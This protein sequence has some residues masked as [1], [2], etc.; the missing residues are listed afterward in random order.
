M[1]KV[2]V[3]QAET[4]KSTVVAPEIF[5]A[6]ARRL[7]TLIVD[8]QLDAKL[9]TQL[10]CEQPE[11]LSPRVYMFVAIVTFLALAVAVGCGLAGRL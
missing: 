7:R 11:T 3:M 4:E 5:T 8:A 6:T 9:D 2:I 1:A 10:Y